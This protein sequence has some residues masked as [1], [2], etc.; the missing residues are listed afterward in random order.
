[1]TDELAPCPCGEIPEKLCVGEAASGSEWA[2]ANGYCCG[3]WNI[4]F[5]TN[6]AAHGT[7]ENNRLAREAWNA[8][9]RGNDNE[10][11]VDDLASLLRRVARALRKF[12]PD[13]DLAERALDYLQSHGLAG[14]RL[15]GTDGRVN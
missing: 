8:A 14:V 2:M 15:R 10:L 11:L 4:E 1:M 12:E 7:E 6:H 3:G 5:R 9:P 13:N